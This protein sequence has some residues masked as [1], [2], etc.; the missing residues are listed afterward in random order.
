MVEALNGVEKGRERRTRRGLVESIGD[1]TSVAPTQMS[2]HRSVH[3]TLLLSAWLGLVLGGCG[4][5]GPAATTQSPTTV[6]GPSTSAT[7]PPPA[8]TLAAPTTT[9]AVTTSAAPTPR[10]V[11]VDFSSFG[12]DPDY[13]VAL[14]VPALDHTADESIAAEI[15]DKIRARFEAEAE[16]FVAA[17]VE[18]GSSEFGPSELDSTYRVTLLGSDL[19]SFEVSFTSYFSGAAHPG[20]TVDALTYDLA[21]ARQLGVDDF[22]VGD[23]FLDTDQRAR[24]AAMIA[25]RIRAGYYGGDEAEF[26]TFVPDEAALVGEA[27]FW[28]SSSTLGVSFSQAIVGPSVFGPVTVEIPFGDLGDLIEAGGYIH[29]LSP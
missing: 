29:A 8:T 16:S 27:A 13:Q 24:L 15:N 4:S 2:T 5:A 25:D 7:L 21:T 11:P 23:G 1:A 3:I 10:V 20:T 28:L 26:T 12:T 9:Q 18:G 17:V 22:L 19:L 14:T 6:A